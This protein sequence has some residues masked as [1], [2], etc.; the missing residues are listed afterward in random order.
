[1]PFPEIPISTLRSL[2]QLMRAAFM[3][4]RARLSRATPPCELVVSCATGAKY[5]GVL[6]VADNRVV[7]GATHCTFDGDGSRG[8]YRRFESGPL[9]DEE[10]Y[11][12]EPRPW[13]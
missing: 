10:E 7:G 5:S 2:A 12:Q 8:G 6:L 9:F 3:F 1:M 13:R 4:V 11:Y